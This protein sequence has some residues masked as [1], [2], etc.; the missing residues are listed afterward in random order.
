[1][2]PP[3]S[4][5]AQ[6]GIDQHHHDPQRNRAV[7]G[8]VSAIEFVA[9]NPEISI[10]NMSAGIPGYHDGMRIAVEAVIANRRPPRG[11]HREPRGAGTWWISWLARSLVGPPPA[12]PLS[13]SGGAGAPKKISC[14]SGRSRVSTRVSSQGKYPGQDQCRRGGTNGQ[15]DQF[16]THRSSFAPPDVWQ[17][18][19]GLLSINCAGS[20]ALSHA[21]SLRP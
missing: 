15:N 5:R 12:G 19:C 21:A 1:M 2:A 11:R 17:S 3:G 20:L 8:F 6:C 9:G 14:A 7:V 16:C 18:A 4:A 13:V 10:L